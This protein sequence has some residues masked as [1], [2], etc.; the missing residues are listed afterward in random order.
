MV[1]LGIQRLVSTYSN[2]QNPKCQDLPKI[3][4]FRGGSVLESQNTQSAKICLN[5]H[6]QGGGCSGNSKYSKCQ[7]LPTFQLGGGGVLESQNPK[8]QD[9]S[10][11]QFLGGGGHS[12]TKSQ[13]RGVLE[14][15]LKNFWKLSLLVHHR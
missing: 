5:F 6:F 2:H 8:C 7:D 9:L 13:N 3:Q 4:F 12:G 15:L 11:L 14:N 1:S 10:K